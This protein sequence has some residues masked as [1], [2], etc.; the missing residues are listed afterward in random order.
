MHPK[1]RPTG[2]KEARRDY[3]EEVLKLQLDVL[4]EE[5]G[6]SV[7]RA[8]NDDALQSTKS[9]RGNCSLK[10]KRE[11]SALLLTVGCFERARSRD[12]LS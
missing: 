5:K 10:G 12:R 7:D 11:A 3:A 2:G 8:G 9:D 1:T 4:S 6:V